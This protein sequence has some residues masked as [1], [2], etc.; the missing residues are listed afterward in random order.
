MRSRPDLVDLFTWS[1]QRDPFEEGKLKVV[2][3]TPSFD[4]S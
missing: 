2:C 4:V 3:G 1:P